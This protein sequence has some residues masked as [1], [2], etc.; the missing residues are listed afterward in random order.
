MEMIRNNRIGY[1]ELLRSEDILNAI[2]IAPF[3]PPTDLNYL[4]F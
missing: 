2:L 1:Y 4:A 3:L